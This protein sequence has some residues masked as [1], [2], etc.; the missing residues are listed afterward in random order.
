MTD[1]PADTVKPAIERLHVMARTLGQRF[2]LPADKHKPLGGIL[3]E[4]DPDAPMNMYDWLL[5][6]HAQAVFEHPNWAVGCISLYLAA[7]MRVQAERGSGP[8]MADPDEPLPY[9][10]RRGGA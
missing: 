4:I 8:A 3:A 1:A 9:W 2:A 6:K 5:V 10:D 7:E